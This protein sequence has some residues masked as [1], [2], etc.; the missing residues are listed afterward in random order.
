[1]LTLYR[2]DFFSVIFNNSVPT[3]QETYI[4]T[5]NTNPLM[6]FY[7]NH[8]KQTNAICGQHRV[9]VVKQVVHTIV[10]TGF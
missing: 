6:L 10:T 8:T 7:H 3:S 1:M 5:A 9:L 2:L 4:S